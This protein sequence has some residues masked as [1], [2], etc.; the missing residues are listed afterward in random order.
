[1]TSFEIL[2]IKGGRVMTNDCKRSSS[3]K[4]GGWLGGQESQVT[5]QL[6]FPERESE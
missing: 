6:S 3:Q 5:G 1:M 4:A 2:S